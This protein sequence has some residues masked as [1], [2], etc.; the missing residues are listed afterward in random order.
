MPRLLSLVPPLVRA[1]E[2]WP[3]TFHV[4]PVLRGGR[5]PA[6]PDGRAAAGS[7]RGARALPRRASRLPAGR[8]LSA[9][10]ARS[11]SD[12]PVLHRRGRP[13]V[14]GRPAARRDRPPGA[15]PGRR[16]DEQHGARARD[17][18]RRSRPGQTTWGSS[19]VARSRATRA[20]SSA[21]TDGLSWFTAIC[22]S[23]RL[24]SETR[25]TSFAMVSR[26]ARPFALV[27]RESVYSAV[28]SFPRQSGAG[29]SSMVSGCASAAV[30]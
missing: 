13:A 6:R 23:T 15:G 20:S 30:A 2:R 22:T 21:R 29:G 7:A 16:P 25:F 12:R 9:Q 26:S 27:S 19:S 10:R 3:T 8:R 17:G 4:P 18:P 1:L 14:C 24:P 5:A 28:S 11:H